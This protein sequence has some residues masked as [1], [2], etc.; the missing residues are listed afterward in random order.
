ML[1]ILGIQ[2]NRWASESL[3][4]LLGEIITRCLTALSMQSKG[5]FKLCQKEKKN[6]IATVRTMRLTVTAKSFVTVFQTV[7]LVGKPEE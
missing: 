3:L 7:F 5:N 6:R 1:V 2:F 4:P